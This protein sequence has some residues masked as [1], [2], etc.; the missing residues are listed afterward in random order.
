LN[1][2]LKP[3]KEFSHRLSLLVRNP[4]IAGFFIGER[5]KFAERKTQLLI[6]ISPEI[7]NAANQEQT[8]HLINVY[9]YIHHA[10]L[11]RHL[12]DEIIMAIDYREQRLKTCY[13]IQLKEAEVRTLESVFTENYFSQLIEDA[14]GTFQLV[15]NEQT[16]SIC[17]ETTYQ[18]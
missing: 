8:T 15:T 12:P 6:E 3:E 9:R 16:L 10:L 5:E 7:P 2:I 14:R 1:D 4:V 13:H 18:E 11:L 17:L